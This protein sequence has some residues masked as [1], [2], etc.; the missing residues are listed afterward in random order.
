MAD[1]SE[2]VRDLRHALEEERRQTALF[3]GSLIPIG[4]ALLRE[5]DLTK[6]LEMIL[7]EAQ[8]LSSADGATL[9]MRRGG[10]LDFFMVLNYSLGVAMGGTSG[11]AITIPPLNLT[12][13]E[14]GEPNLSSAACYSV[15]RHQTLNIENIYEHESFDF[16]GS[17]QF[18]DHYGY[19]TT[20]LLTVP[21]AGP[22]GEPVAAVQMINAL[23]PETGAC[24]PFSPSIQR[25]VESLAALA[26]GALESFGVKERLYQQ[27][28]L[29]LRHLET[30]QARLQAEL[31][32]AEKYIR[33][34]LPPPC[35]RPLKID[36]L[37]ASCTELG[38]DSFGYHEIDSDHWALYILDVCGHGVSAALLSVTAV[39]VLRSEALPGVDFR[40]P[41]AVLTALNDEFLMCHQNNM[42]FT[43]WYGVYRLSTRE[44]RFSSAGH[45]PAILVEP[46]AETANKLTAPG[47]VLG[48]RE[49]K[50]YTTR[51]VV[52]A[53]G[54]ML[55]L[56]SDGTYEI[57]L[58]DGSM[59]PFA[60]F[61]RL[62]A[63]LPAAAPDALTQL[64][65]TIR[66]HRAPERLED[67]FSVVRIF[68]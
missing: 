19:H 32:E 55:Y 7:R 6:L 53:P 18:D 5:T 45:A 21:L 22:D 31:A 20:S 14:D 62:L 63:A 68:T 54:A 30:T 25:V 26:A 52:L 1:S 42:Y 67:D 12:R 51:T 11:H 3:A 57:R 29:Y 40:D 48:A 13:P 34:I 23:D 8:R 15:L 39:K 16:S 28:Q 4:M 17:R 66:G 46:G 59:W 56:L 2:D 36:W 58:R 50:V 47:L 43:I 41:G 27:Q 64:H 24:V 10:Q 60:E 9:Y 35:E 37:L 65:E 49:G 61:L 33:A 44:L 38:G